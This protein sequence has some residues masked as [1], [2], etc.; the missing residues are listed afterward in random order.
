[1]LF[2][3]QDPL[4]LFTIL[5][6]LIRSTI[7]D[8]DETDV[9]KLLTTAQQSQFYTE[10]FQQVCFLYFNPHLQL[11]NDALSKKFSFVHVVE[12]EIKLEDDTENSLTI[13]LDSKVAS[14]TPPRVSSGTIRP[15]LQMFEVVLHQ[16]L[17]SHYL[18][19]LTTHKDVEDGG[20]S[21]K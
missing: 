12:S 13:R 16:L 8:P 17:R 7:I 3:I 4:L 11:T 21:K 18:S 10:L 1:M 14:K 20:N 6:E 2:M 19:H 5:D 9:I 15:S